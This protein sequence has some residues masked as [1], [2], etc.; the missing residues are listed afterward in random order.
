MGRVQLDQHVN[1]AVRPCLAA[2]DRAKN[3]SMLHAALTQFGF[4][5]SENSQ[6]LWQRGLHR[7]TRVYFS[8]HTA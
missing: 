4:V 3:R 1:V 5:R 7:R 8:R 2:S 6:N